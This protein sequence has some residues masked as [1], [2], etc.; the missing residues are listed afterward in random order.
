MGLKVVDKLEL[1]KLFVSGSSERNMD[2]IKFCFGMAET[3][4]LFIGKQSSVS[5]TILYKISTPVLFGVNHD[6]INKGNAKRLEIK[7]PIQ[8]LMFVTSLI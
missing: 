4:Y 3:R 2:L 6:C 5:S 8:S 7:T 1:C